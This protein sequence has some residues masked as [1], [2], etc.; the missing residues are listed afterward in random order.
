MKTV[1]A[2]T[3]GPGGSILFGIDDDH[4][5]VGIP[6]QMIDRLKD[7]LTQTIGSWV[8]PRPTFSFEVLPAEDGQKGVLE[9]YV[10]RGTR[11]YGCARPG[12]TPT[13]YVR[14]YATSVKARPAEIEEM[15]RSRTL[16]D[17]ALPWWH[18][19]RAR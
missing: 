13:V 4:N 2:F 14:H 16:T 18:G 7:Q 15:V 11:L 9:L 8:D 3:N 6:M 1:C 5:I 12:D 17:A 19:M 10:A